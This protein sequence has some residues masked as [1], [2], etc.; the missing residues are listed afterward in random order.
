M[1]GTDQQLTMHF[2]QA[3][4]GKLLSAAGYTGSEIQ[5][6]RA[7]LAII[8][9][10]GDFTAATSFVRS[11]DPARCRLKSRAIPVFLPTRL[12]HFSRI[13]SLISQPRRPRR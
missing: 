13:R 3:E 10:Y 11:D 4:A 7:S 1:V 6:N 8:Y 5:S 9:S 12:K 2:D